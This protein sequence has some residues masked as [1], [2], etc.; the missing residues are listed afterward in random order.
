MGAPPPLTGAGWGDRWGPAT[1][2]PTLI[3]S[4]F[5]KRGFI[6][7]TAYDTTSILK[8]ITQRWFAN[9]FHFPDCEPYGIKDERVRRL[10]VAA[11]HSGS[12]GSQPMVG[13]PGAAVLEFR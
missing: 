13:Y 9:Y 11:I 2:I 6:D 10:A 8:L 1:R 5:A 3:V 4:P 12:N 7:K